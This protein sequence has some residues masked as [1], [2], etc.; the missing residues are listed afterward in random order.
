MVEAGIHGLRKKPN[1]PS[2]KHY[3]T[4]S[5]TR[6]IYSSYEAKWH[7]DSCERIFD[8]LKDGFVSDEDSEEPDNRNAYHCHLCN[9]DIC[10]QCFRGTFHPFHKHRLKRAHASILYPEASG[11]WRC[12]AC[13]R[14]FTELTEQD[15][16]TC[17][18][19]HVDLCT[20][21]YKGRW[22]HALHNSD[23]HTLMP[24]HPEIKYHYYYDWSCDNCY[25]VFHSANTPEVLF[26]C[27]DCQYD[28]CPDCFTGKK[29]HLHQHNLV[30]VSRRHIRQRCSECRDVITERH[31]RVCR[32]LAC[33]F[34]LCDR[35]YY[36]SKP[37]PHPFHPAHP[38]ELCDA[39]EV[40]P[41]SAGMWHCDRCT[42][43]DSR[44]EPSPL[45]PQNPM[46][47]CE[48]CQFDLCQ[49]CYQQG[50]RDKRPAQP[51]SLLE[52][53]EP[54]PVFQRYAMQHYSTARPVTGTQPLSYLHNPTVPPRRLCLICGKNPAVYTFVH[55]GQPHYEYNSKICCY[56]CG[57]DT[58]NYKRRC[59]V[60]N[61]VPE[62][63]TNLS[64]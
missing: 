24:V 55:R 58:V 5:D 25:R 47:H 10:T 16:Y 6:E 1:H 35:C 13:K 60:C 36:T 26:H 14:V 59:P 63:V 29:H 38:L 12:D 39:A 44:K 11:Q 27:Q 15:C 19:C 61:R 42:S 37:K 22:R 46:Y 64:D 7:C 56:T 40:Y 21:C 52:T 34:T 23:S 41:Q 57:I 62:N 17:Q 33:D 4:K 54:M 2:H 20:N 50:L 48:I 18:D 3:L 49:Q 45:S 9:Y 53:E 28:L 32:D 30:E 31:A 8:G 51:V 43:N